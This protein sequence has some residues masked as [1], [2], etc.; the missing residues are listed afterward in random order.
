MEESLAANKR[1]A[2]FE[3]EVIRLSRQE[4]QF[5]SYCKTVLCNALID[6]QRKMNRR[7]QKECFLED[8]S[9][10]IRY[11]EPNVCF[12]DQYTFRILDIEIAIK[13]LLLGA[14]LEILSENQ[15]DIVLL[16]YFLDMKDHEIAK[17]MHLVR[18]TVSYR[19]NCSLK[20]LREVMEAC[21]NEK[22]EK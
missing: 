8:M 19:R 6:H 10:D 16:S 20:K 4:E 22:K 9:S 18:R 15:R 2:S 12:S 14:A 5:D 13:N 11:C 17:Q 3:K 1:G 7:K 21:S